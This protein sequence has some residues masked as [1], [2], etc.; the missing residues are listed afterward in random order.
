VSATV[1]ALVLLSALLHAAWSASIKGSPHPL[2]FS[3]GQHLLVLPFAVLGVASVAGELLTPRLLACAA[4]TAVA[5]GLYG[6]WLALALERADLTL[7]YP[8]VR[9]TPALLPLLAVPLL[10]ETPSPLGAAGIAVVVGGIW[11]VHGR[12]LRLRALGAPALRYAWLTLL[13][14][15]GYSLSDKA[16]MTALASGDYRGWLPPALV[17]YCV[18]VVSSTAVFLPL[19]LRRVRRADLE[20]TL[21]GEGWRAAA[22]VAVSLVGYGLILAAF[23]HAPASYVVAVR[24][25]SVLFAAWI[26]VALLGE[27]PDRGR[28]V[29]AAATVAGVGLIGLGG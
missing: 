2:S 29:G 21:R 12:G 14:T 18:I 10:G 3:L 27:R 6:Y 25:S 4:G 20:R 8:I 19:A 1:I 22:A 23:E 17:W 13:A 15:V 28:L 24:Q 9:S 16:A 5:H 7:A 11:L 26:G